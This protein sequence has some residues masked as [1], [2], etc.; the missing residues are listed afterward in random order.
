MVSHLTADGVADYIQKLT[1]LT[2]LKRETGVELYAE[3][4]DNRISGKTKRVHFTVVKSFFAYAENQKL[5]IEEGMGKIFGK[6]KTTKADRKGKRKPFSSGDLKLLFESAEYQAGLFKRP[7]DFWCPLLS[8]FTSARQEEVCQLLRD[9]VFKDEESGEWVI[10]INDDD[11]KKLKNEHS[12]R[13]L[14]IH[15]MLKKL[16]FIEF[17]LTVSKGEK[18]FPDEER[19]SLGHFGAFSNRFND[20]KDRV[21]VVKSVVNGKKEMKDF[22]TLRHTFTDKLLG[23]RPP[24]PDY[25]KN[26][27][28]G[29]SDEGESE[30]S[31]T[32]FE[33]PS[34]QQK[35]DY[36][37]K[38]K[39]PEIDFTKIKPNGW[40]RKLKR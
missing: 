26:A 36:I 4:D 1:R 10:S 17:V 13:I 27:I 6:F 3:Q 12:K 32:Y 11:G 23:L 25:I 8:L 30:N 24:P 16:G 18:L 33:G 5:P 20:Y 7:S 34:I 35:K 38:V 19:N 37:F 21:G 39:Y 28:T 31:R 2:R 40:K 22:H 29:H 9:D 14:P 15:P